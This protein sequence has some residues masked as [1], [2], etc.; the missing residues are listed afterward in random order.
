MTQPSILSHLASLFTPQ[1]ENLAT[2]ALAFVLGYSEAARGAVA[3]LAIGLGALLPSDLTYA[4]QATQEDGKRPDLAGKDGE[5]RVRLLV[6]A[7][8]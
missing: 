3:E 8:F 7:K 2:E 5:G 4:T 6:E 1:T